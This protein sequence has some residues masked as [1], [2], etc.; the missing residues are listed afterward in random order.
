MKGAY[1][2]FVIVLLGTTFILTGFS[3]VEITL[4]YNQAR[5]FQET[6]VSLIERNNRYDESIVS[7]INQ[8]D[9]NCRQCSYKVEQVNDRFL[10]KVQFKVNVIILAYKNIGE[11]KT[12]TQSIL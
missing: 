5:I 10:V 11:I 12:Y 1:E 6:I 4:N 2:Y 8:S 9:A 7:L 3:M